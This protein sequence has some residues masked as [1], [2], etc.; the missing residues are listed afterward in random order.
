VEKRYTHIHNSHVLHAQY[1]THIHNCCRVCA[2]LSCSMYIER[3]TLHIHRK[4]ER[5]RMSESVIRT[6]I[7]L[8]SRACLFCFIHIYIHKCMYMFRYI[9]IYVY[10]YSEVRGSVGMRVPRRYRW[11]GRGREVQSIL[12]E[13]PNIHCNYESPNLQLLLCMRPANT[14]VCNACA[15][16]RMGYCR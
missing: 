11:R 13:H 14:Q 6:H 7:Q 16:R 10:I 2:Y 12:H 15:H 4:R 8:L 5:Q 3:E 9:C 1:T